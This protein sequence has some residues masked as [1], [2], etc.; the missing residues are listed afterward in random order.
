MSIVLG[1]VRS[2][3]AGLG[4]DTLFSSLDSGESVLGPWE[5]CERKSGGGDDRSEVHG[6]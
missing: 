4:Q 5:W 1:L 3:Q 2:G 6:V